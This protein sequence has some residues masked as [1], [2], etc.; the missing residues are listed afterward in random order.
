MTTDQVRKKAMD[1]ITEL[2][3]RECT[4]EK[5]AWK[6]VYYIQGIT[7]L[8]AEICEELLEGG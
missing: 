7:D 3:A 2:N 1:M 4:D 6:L 5:E 8:S